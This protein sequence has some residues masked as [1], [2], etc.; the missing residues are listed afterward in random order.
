MVVVVLLH[1]PAVKLVSAALANA[2]LLVCSSTLRFALPL[3]SEHAD[4]AVVDPSV[5]TRDSGGRIGTNPLVRALSPAAAPPFV[6]YLPSGRTPVPLL[7]ALVHLR[8]AML[9][10][11]GVDD[12]PD[13]LRSIIEE[14]TQA[15]T[16]NDVLAAVEA[17]IAP[18]RRSLREALARA[19]RYPMECDSVD[20]LAASAGVS[21]RQ[22]RRELAG[23]GL[24]PPREWL[25]AARVLR[26]HWELRDSSA[27]I[28]H[29]AA[30]LGYASEEPLAN[31]VA[32]VI[33]GTPSDLRDMPAADLVTIVV[34]RLA[35]TS[36]IQSPRTSSD[37][38]AAVDRS[39]EPSANPPAKAAG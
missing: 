38:A 16:P 36:R 8:P 25:V 7:A 17:E 27:K 24:G 39:V 18:L 13:R 23:A 5:A 29:V 3:E 31:D 2:R 21:T 4:V 12:Q 34:R 9:A 35:P 30:K 19:V 33:D 28:R 11:R 20:G 14:A 6:L 37:R 26:V 10:V 1:A 32:C 15:R 22:V